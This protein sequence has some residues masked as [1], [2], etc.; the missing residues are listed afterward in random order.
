MTTTNSY[1]DTKAIDYLEAIKRN[2]LESRNSKSSS[3]NFDMTYSLPMTS[4]IGVVT[5]FTNT[6]KT[7]GDYEITDNTDQLVAF[8]P[9]DYDVLDASNS[10]DG[11][12]TGTETYI[13][14][15]PEI[16]STHPCRKA[17][18]FN[19]SS[20]IT[21]ANESNFDFDYTNTFSVAF[22]VK[23]GSIAADQGLVMK[24]N[25]LTTGLGWKVYFQNTSDLL[26]FK[27]ADGTTAYSITSSTSL[28]TSKYYH[29]VCTFS[30]NSNRSGMKI[31]VDGTLEA[32]GTSS[33]ISSTILN[34]VSP[35]IGAES[36]GGSI[37]TGSIS[38]VQIWN[39]ELSSTDVT[40]LYHGKQ[41]NFQEPYGNLLTEAGDDITTEASVI[42]ETEQGLLNPATLGLSDIT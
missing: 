29:I 35:V 39:S 18:S 41:V 27:L 36:D 28:T 4:D 7:L 17:F 9:F 23:M 26:V 25:D 38:D 22:R 31:Y 37:F 19:G 21:L 40:D 6:E 2:Q 14:F 3:S 11:T 13:D 32:T 33:A 30:G 34:S 10:N 24:S 15:A 42:I 16:S 20:Y 5:T 8:L 12:V 1:K